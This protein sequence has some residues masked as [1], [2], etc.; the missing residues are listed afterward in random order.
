MVRE[1]GRALQSFFWDNIKA[2]AQDWFNHTG[3]ARLN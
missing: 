2:Q 3:W 1:G